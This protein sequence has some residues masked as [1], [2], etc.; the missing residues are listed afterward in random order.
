MN[1]GK[2]RIS[3]D[4][5]TLQDELN[6]IKAGASVQILSVDGA[7]ALLKTLRELGEKAVNK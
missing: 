4:I 6:S 3:K 2:I 7:T 1:S 5:D